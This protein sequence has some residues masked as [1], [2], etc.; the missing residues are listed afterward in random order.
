MTAFH[1]DAT[2][3]TLISIDPS[4]AQATTVGVGLVGVEARGATFDRD[5]TLWVVDS[6]NDNL[7]EVDATAGT[8]TSTVGLTGGGF[9]GELDL[10]ARADGKLF[11]THRDSIYEVDSATGTTTL[12][13]QETELS[14]NDGNLD[15][16]YY[17]G[18]TF[19]MNR[20]DQLFALDVLQVDEVN[21]YD[22]ED[23]FSRTAEFTATNPFDADF[24]DLASFITYPGNS[25]Q[26]NY[27]GTDITGTVALGNTG[28]GVSIEGSHRNVI[29]TDGDG[30][31]D[32]FGRQR[33]QR[34]CRH[35][36]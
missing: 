27:I 23:G 35:R 9:D 17:D 30:V 5:G 10:A 14:S 34:Q 20:G 3:S 31:N 19:T 2:G 12:I 24:G 25:I 13:H 22:T 21:S 36:G 16:A 33:N 8:V 6:A 26:G 15:V 11:L 7:L 4:T 29:G 32:A 1:V 18:S 28:R